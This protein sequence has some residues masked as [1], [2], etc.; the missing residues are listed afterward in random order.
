MHL[1][2]PPPPG[3][4]LVLNNKEY[5]THIGYISF[6]F[7]KQGLKSVS[8]FSPL[9]YYISYFVKTTVVDK[10]NSSKPT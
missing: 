6:F 3:Y 10:F 8:K 2:S 5:E 9:N 4:G 1:W 7:L